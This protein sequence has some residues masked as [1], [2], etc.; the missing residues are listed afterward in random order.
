[1][2]R[3]SSRLF[4]NGKDHKDIY[5]QGHYH[6]AMYL[7]SELVWE[8]KND[9]YGE[10]EFVVD[11]SIHAKTSFSFRG[12]FS[13]NWG[14]GCVETVEH[15]DIFTG[16]ASHTY[17]EKSIHTIKI[18]GI[19]LLFDLNSDG[20]KSIKEVLTP[21]PKMKR[22]DFNRYFFNC[23][24]LTKIPENLFANYPNVTEF[25][26][27]FEKCV[28]LTSIPENLFANCP[29]ATD[30]ES[31][32]YDCV[33]LTNIPENLFS[34]CPNATTFIGCFMFCENL[35]SIPK[36]LFENC[37]NAS[38]FGFCFKFCYDL[39]GIPENLF[40]NCPNVTSF[41]GCFESCHGITSKVPELWKRTNVIEHYECFLGCENAVNY[42]DIPDDW[43]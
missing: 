8:K 32:F 23:G 17:S 27:C 21:I 1:M 34:N 25:E 2:G 19:I 28:N 15:L 18:S 3:Q 39:T 7:G 20:R 22:Y 38:N 10:F 43:K 35:T 16:D 40:A 4:F 24:N 36:N 14:D 33:N 30:F 12:R 13:V 6:K 26:S 41:D 31:C 42:A 5:Y 11:S 29:N 37:P 9:Y